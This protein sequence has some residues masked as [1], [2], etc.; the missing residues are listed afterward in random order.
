MSI[1]ANS[2]ILA[3]DVSGKIDTAGTGLT[4]SGTTLSLASL[5]SANATIG[6]SSAGTLAYSGTFTMPYIT[7]DV[8]GRVTGGGTRTLTMPAKP[9]GGTA[10]AVGNVVSGNP[11]GNSFTLPSGGTWRYLAFTHNDV[12]VYSPTGS[13]ASGG[14]TISLTNGYPKNIIYIAVRVA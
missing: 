2:K 12:Y 10:T 6:A 9:S 13:S 14:A 1:S 7:R 5:H 4:K 3:S 11:T 8:Y